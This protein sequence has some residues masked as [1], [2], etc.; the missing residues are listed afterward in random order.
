MV[1]DDA[2]FAS[3]GGSSGFDDGGS[4]DDQSFDDGQSVDDDAL[5]NAS[6]EGSID[7]VPRGS[8]PGVSAAFKSVF[9]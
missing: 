3:S 5:S 9:Q 8:G 4:F 7:P 2:R 6:S 1:P